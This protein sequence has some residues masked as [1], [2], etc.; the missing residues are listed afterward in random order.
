MDYRDYIISR[1]FTLPKLTQDLA[2]A[3]EEFKIVNDMV[4]KERSNILF[5]AITVNIIALYLVFESYLGINQFNLIIA[6]SILW[7]LSLSL[8]L[9]KDKTKNKVLETLLE[10]VLE[11]I[12]ACSVAYEHKLIDNREE[13]IPYLRNAEKIYCDYEY[14]VYPNKLDTR[15]Y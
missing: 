1:N 10:T 6:S 15:N 11:K 13:L 5:I 4:Q 2:V 14:F 7:I 12:A 8:I 3:L 9:N